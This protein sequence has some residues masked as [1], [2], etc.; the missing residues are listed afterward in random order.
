MKRTSGT[1]LWTHKWRVADI[2]TDASYPSIYWSDRNGRHSIFEASHC[3]QQRGHECYLLSRELSY[4][5]NLW[6]GS[7][8]RLNTEGLLK[9]GNNCGAVTKHCALDIRAAP[10]I[11]SV[12]N[13]TATVGPRNII[14]V[15]WCFMFY[16][17][18][19]E[20]TIYLCSSAG[21]KHRSDQKNYTK[22]Y[23]GKF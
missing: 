10:V 19:R 20:H 4:H 23:I 22:L 5:G 15:S 17:H 3:R 12:A 6:G 1:E 8:T 16:V 21:F 9:F 13:N 2:S 7:S 14:C 18:N 11:N